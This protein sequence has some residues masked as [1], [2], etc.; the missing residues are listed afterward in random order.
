[1]P[2]FGILEEAE[3][4]ARERSREL[5]AETV[6]AEETGLEGEAVRGRRLPG[7]FPG[8]RGVASPEVFRTVVASR[9]QGTGGRRQRRTSRR[10]RR[11]DGRHG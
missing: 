5:L 2:G 4:L 9:R 10:R 1:M 8:G 3:S 11:P 7:R 6:V